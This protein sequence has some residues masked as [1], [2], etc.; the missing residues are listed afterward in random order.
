MLSERVK[1]VVPF[2]AMDV[3][4]R[5]RQLERAGHSII[6][7]EVGEPDYATPAGIKAAAVRAIEADVTHYTAARGEHTLVEA[8]AASYRERYGVAVAP[9]QI[10]VSAGTSPVLLMAFLAVVNPGDEVII[11]RPYY[12]CYP[13]FVRLAGGTP[14]FVDTRPEDGFRVKAAAVRAAMTRRTRAILL[15]SPANPRVR[16]WIALRFRR[17]PIWA[18]RSYQTRSITACST[19]AKKSRRSN[20]RKM[21]SWSMVSRKL[22]P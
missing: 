21:R 18:S 7:F 8:I 11:P 6:H 15:A 9:E 4:A 1:S 13:N 16:C 14:V 5:A 22:T 20:A 17:S 2:L 19:R 3:L 10:I 12:A